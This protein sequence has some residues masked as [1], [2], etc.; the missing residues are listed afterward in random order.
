[1]AFV[2]KNLMRVI[3]FALCMV[4]FITSDEHDKNS[5]S[6]QKNSFY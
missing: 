1:M 2:F 4:Y 5:T 3:T 6:E